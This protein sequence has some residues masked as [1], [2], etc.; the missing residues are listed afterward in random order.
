MKQD[1]GYLNRVNWRTSSFRVA[2]RRVNSIVPFSFFGTVS[3][4]YG[5]VSAMLG[6]GS[7]RSGPFGLL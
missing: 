1:R 7:S 6:T 4:R 5:R 3:H 2:G